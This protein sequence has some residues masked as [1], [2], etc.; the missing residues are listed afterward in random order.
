[1]LVSI[2]NNDLVDLVEIWIEGNVSCIFIV[3]VD[4][5]EL[6]FG[7]NLIVFWID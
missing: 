5:Y 6:F 2:F 4:V 1:M 3:F 7:K